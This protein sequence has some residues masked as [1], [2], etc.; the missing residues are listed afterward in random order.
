MKWF[1]VGGIR[2]FRIGRLQL[3]FCVCKKKPRAETC[4]EVFARICN[5]PKL[6]QSKADIILGDLFHLHHEPRA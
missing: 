3:S 6:R 2:F 4:D 1:K 5:G